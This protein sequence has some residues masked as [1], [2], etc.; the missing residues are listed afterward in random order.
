MTDA[1]GQTLQDYLFGAILVLLNML[2]VFAFGPTV[3]IPS[4]EPVES[5]NQ[6]LADRLM[7]ELVEEIRALETAR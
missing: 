3:F 4:E 1:R 5:E 2:G 6:Q 7:V